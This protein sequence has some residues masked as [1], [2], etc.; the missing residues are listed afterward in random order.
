MFAVQRQEDIGVHPAKALQLQHLPADGDLPAQHRELGVLPGD[1]GIGANSLG[2]K[3]FHRLGHLLGDDRD[4]VRRTVGRLGDD[5]GFLTGDPRDVLAEVF[6]VIDADRGDDRNRR[7][8]HVG[9]IPATAHPHFYDRDFDRRIGERRERHRGEHLELAHRRSTGGLRLR[10]D[11]LHERLDLA[12]GR[13]VLRRADGC[14]VDRDAFDRRLQV[15]AGGSA[16]APLQ[17]GQERVDH[18]HHR[19]FAVGPRDVDRRIAELR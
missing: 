4:G 9:G 17:R 6:D 12:V 16:G 18:P 14:S 10:I 7:V 3:H 15:R 13:H 5:A 19:G 11:H 8:D 1:R 2:H